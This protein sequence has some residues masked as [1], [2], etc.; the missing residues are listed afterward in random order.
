MKD[1]DIKNFV[2]FMSEHFTTKDEGREITH[3]S[4]GPVAVGYMNCRGAFS[5]EGTDFEKFMNLYKKVVN[6]IPLHIIERPQYVGP[7]V[8]D[9]DYKTGRWGRERLYL[10]KHI[11]GVI[12]IYNEIISEYF[13]ISNDDL[14]AFV[15]EKSEPTPDGK[16]IYK[17]GFHILYPMFAMNTD[18]RYFIFDIAKNNLIDRNVFGDIHLEPNFKYEEILDVSVVARNGM[19][20]YGSCKDGRSPYYLTKIY[21]HDMSI[22]K[23]DNYDDIELIS[24]LSLRRFSEDDDIEL[25]KKYN[26]EDFYKDEISHRAERYC[27][28]GKKEKP[29][30]DLEKI[31]ENIKNDIKQE[32]KPN[33]KFEFKFLDVNGKLAYDLVKMLSNDRAKTYKDWSA[34]GWALYTISKDTLFPV[35]EEF[36][37]RVPEKYEEGCCEKLWYGA[38]D[39]GIRLGMGSLRLWAMHDSLE[40]Y[41]KF[42]KTRISN[43]VERGISGTHDDIAD[44]IREMYWQSYVCSSITKHI[45]YEFQQDCH[46]WVM[47]QDAYTLK[48]KISN[49][50]VKKFMELHRQKIKEAEDAEGIYQDDKIKQS[51]KIQAIYNKLKSDSFLSSV[52]NTCARKFY[53]PKFEESLNSNPYLI[54]FENGVYDLREMIFRNGSP[55]DKITMSVGYNYRKYKINDPEV[56]EIEKFFGTVQ[57]DKDLRLYA[58]CMISSFLDGRIRDQN[59]ILWTGSGCHAKNEKI[60]MFDKSIKLSQEIN[61]GD[62]VMGDDGR[63][64][65][66]VAIYTGKNKMH[67]VRILKD[68]IISDVIR[69]TAN[70]RLAFKCY[71][72]PE[73]TQTHDEI[74][75]KDIYWV[76]YHE[77]L[78]GGPYESKRKFYNLDDAEEFIENNLNENN[79][80]NN[81][82]N[83]MMIF[84]EIYPITISR[85]LLMPEEMRKYYYLF[86]INDDTKYSCQ[87]DEIVYDDDFIGFELDGNKRYVMGNGIITYNSNGKSSTT[88]L[89]HNT[90]GDY[91]SVLPVTVLTKKRGDSSSATPELADKKGK[92]FLAIQEPESDDQIYVGKMKE[93]TAG[94]DKI[95]ARALYCDPFYYKP[96]FKLILACNNLPRIDAKDYGTWRRIRVLEF[97]SKF[98][99]NPDPNDPTQYKKDTTFEERMKKWNQPFVWL[100]LNKYYPI[101]NEKEHGLTDLE[102]PKVTEFT[103]NYKTANDIYNEFLSRTI[104]ETKNMNDG[105]NL[106]LLFEEFKEWM[107][108]SYPGRQINKKEFVASLEK[109][110]GVKVGKDI[111]R[112][113][114]R[115]A[116]DKIEDL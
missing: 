28:N 46:K 14:K 20:L 66:V 114:K 95:L 103:N 102:P 54:G 92:R 100:L 18:K 116:D 64:R 115:I 2:E 51:G 69:V 75:G 40:E 55:D 101:Y 106:G 50:V 61:L 31:K 56:V 1:R 85:Y 29:K 58:L 43:F 107:R 70:H 23:N 108:E 72:K 88:D 93:L 78:E 71:F 3:T 82:N 12:Q 10:N 57:P 33:G 79:L 63:E 36:S 60:R 109:I 87:I 74:F 90:L 81:L 41:D 53:D 52:V 91:S 8:I 65:M 45:W 6:K 47:V 68:D 62:K 25:K 111:V 21:N 30:K 19:L 38:R 5:I 105:E 9:I 34:V 13:S 22:E 44:V 48:N 96:Q 86:K 112:G 59:F 89:I 80:N 16:S 15:F 99:N 11:E 98:V 39:D 83:D 7:L 42:I 73:I 110:P 67:Q 35:F 4:Y 32:D 84:G 49:D 97:T 27:K 26:N 24:L 37:K 113:I 76:T 94:N 104:I 17:D 77:Y